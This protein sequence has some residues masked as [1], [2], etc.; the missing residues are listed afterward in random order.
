ML[1]KL[2]R[3]SDSL[4]SGKPGHRFVDY[5]DRRKKAEGRS[6]TWKSAG[7]VILGLVL[8][9]AGLVLSLPP[10]VPGFLLWIPGLGLLAVRFRILAVYLDKLE[11]LGRALWRR[12]RDLGKRLVSR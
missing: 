4:R 6:G 3:I 9:A 10:G 5:H 1:S 8:L 12:V 7:Y 2:K 11:R